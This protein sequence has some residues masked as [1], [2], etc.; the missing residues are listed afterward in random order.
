MARQR[1]RNARRGRPAPGD[2]GPTSPSLAAP[3]LG[4]A[5]VLVAVLGFVLVARGEITAAPILLVIAYLVLI[6]LA[7]TRR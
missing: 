5:G 4:A 3:L 2:R 1:A 6:P 7:L